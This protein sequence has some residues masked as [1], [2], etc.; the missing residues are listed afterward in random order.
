[1]C[2]RFITFNLVLSLKIKKLDIALNREVLS[3][4]SKL[5]VPVWHCRTTFWTVTLL[6]RITDCVFDEN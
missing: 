6:I 1:M 5:S 3:T 2:Q 4:S